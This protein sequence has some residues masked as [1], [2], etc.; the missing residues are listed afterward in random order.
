MALFL[1]IDGGGTKTACVVGDESSVLG[2][3]TAGGSNVVR[4]GE[5]E[6]RHNLHV[7]IRQACAAAHV[8]PANVAS[9]CIGV[10]GV[11]ASGVAEQVQ[12]AVAEVVPGRV[13]VVGDMT[14]AM[15]AAFGSG[16]GVV[17]IAGT[18][19]IAFGRNERGE[20]ARA[21]GWGYAISDEG[22]AQ[23]IGREAVTL[24]LRCHD[25]GEATAL[26]PR[27]M[28]AWSATSLDDVV[29]QANASPPPNFSELAPE[30]VAAAELGDCVARELLRF[31]A[32]NLADLA[33]SVWLRL[34]RGGK[35]GPVAMIGGVFRSSEIIRTE[36][37]RALKCKRPDSSFAV[38]PHVVEPVMGALAMARRALQPAANAGR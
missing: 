16:P 7:A 14:I 31:A 19:S 37:A 29:R 21:G 6:A 17:V 2:S 4:V 34:W 27:I 5:M 36:F 24:S 10:A 35:P 11:S 1:G 13:E 30:V 9:A 33:D 12:R 8:E 32:E 18:G 3:A 26:R 22:S 28:A 15:E 25:R 20:M 23:W 38:I